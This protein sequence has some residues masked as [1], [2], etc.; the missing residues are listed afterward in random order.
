MP[1][2]EV[3]YSLY[4]FNIPNRKSRSSGGAIHGAY[5]TCLCCKL[6][7]RKKEP[8]CPACGSQYNHG[9]IPEE[10]PREIEERL[11]REYMERK[12]K[13]ADALARQTHFKNLYE[14]Y[15]KHNVELLKKQGLNLS[16]LTLGD[17]SLDYMRVNLWH[18]MQAVLKE[19]VETYAWQEMNL[20]LRDTVAIFYDIQFAELYQSH[21]LGY[22]TQEGFKMAFRSL[23][24]RAVLSWITCTYTGWY[25]LDNEKIIK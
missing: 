20:K 17:E 6:I 13:E 22:L 3:K 12:A 1:D 5:I 16:S 14:N 7:F 19:V 18:D 11:A 4:G 10:L 15:E 25:L 24:I 9:V 2:D 23:L 21:C 8:V